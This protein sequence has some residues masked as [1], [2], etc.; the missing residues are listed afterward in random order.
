[1]EVIANYTDSRKNERG[2]GFGSAEKA[3]RL[4][5]ATACDVGMTKTT[6]QVVPVKILDGPHSSIQDALR[7]LQP[8]P[9][10]DRRAA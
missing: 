9:P 7:A 8:G 2:P 1:M 6:R 5:G 10:A 4:A 3:G